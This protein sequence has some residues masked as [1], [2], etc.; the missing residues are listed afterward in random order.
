MIEHVEI[1]F[2]SGGGVRGVPR[3]FKNKE[4]DANGAF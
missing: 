3:E 4:K 2:E 1:S